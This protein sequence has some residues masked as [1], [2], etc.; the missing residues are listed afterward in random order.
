MHNY[1]LTDS[2]G[3][4]WTR[5]NA[6]R[7][8]RLYDT[9]HTITICPCKCNPFNPYYS[10]GYEL[11]KPSDTSDTWDTIVNA[12]MFYNCNYNELG[13]YPAYYVQSDVLTA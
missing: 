5:V 3:I 6:T 8:R 9:G 1:T 4:N 13:L 2:N 10:T 7:A 12:F 11:V